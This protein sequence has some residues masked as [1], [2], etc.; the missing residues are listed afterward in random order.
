MSFSPPESEP[1]SVY[2]RLSTSSRRPTQRAADKWESARFS[3]IFRGLELNPAKWRYLVPPMLRT[4]NASRWAAV[5]FM[6]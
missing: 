5:E 6:N 2:G 3:S 1:T 4:G